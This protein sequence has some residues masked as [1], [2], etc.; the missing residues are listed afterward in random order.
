MSPASNFLARPQPKERALGKLER[1]ADPVELDP[2]P[3]LRNESGVCFELVPI[4]DW[5]VR[6]NSVK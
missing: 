1:K 5:L 6:K 3:T 2:S 4:D